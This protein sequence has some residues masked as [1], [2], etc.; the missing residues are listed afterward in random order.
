M[1]PTELN[2]VR[3]IFAILAKLAVFAEEFAGG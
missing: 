3:N 2:P 1:E